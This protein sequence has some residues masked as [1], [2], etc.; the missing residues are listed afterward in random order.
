MI[1]LPFLDFSKTLQ[2]PVCMTHA[3][4]A[5]DSTPQSQLE[6]V[7]GPRDGHGTIAW[8]SRVTPQ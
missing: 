7:G 4:D 3:D 6:W 8:V 1:E 5:H 2:M